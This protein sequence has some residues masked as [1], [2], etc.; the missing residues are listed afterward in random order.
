MPIFTKIQGAVFEIL[1]N[2]KFSNM[3]FWWLVPCLGFGG[4]ALPPPHCLLWRERG[5]LDGVTS[6]PVH[7]NSFIL[8]LRRGF[9]VTTVPL[10]HITTFDT[11]TMHEQ[12]LSC[13]ERDRGVVLLIFKK[14]TCYSKKSILFWKYEKKT[15]KPDKFSERQCRRYKRGTAKYGTPRSAT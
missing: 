1:K 5:H 13:P 2:F 6:P 9:V 4:G 14:P 8:R 12:Q 7:P 15:Q 3:Y 11:V 10:N